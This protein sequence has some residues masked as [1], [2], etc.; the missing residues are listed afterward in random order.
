MVAADAVVG[1]TVPVATAPADLSR[2]AL[3]F[4]APVTSRP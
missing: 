2:A 4:L 1:Q 3:D